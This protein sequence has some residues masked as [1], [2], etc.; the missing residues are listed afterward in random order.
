MPLGIRRARARTA[1]TAECALTRYT[2]FTFHLSTSVRV[3]P[4]NLTLVFVHMFVVAVY[5]SSA[6]K[7]EG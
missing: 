6:E 2:I 3:Q 7:N 5:S 1:L 4:E